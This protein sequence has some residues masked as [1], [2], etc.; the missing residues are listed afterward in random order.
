MSAPPEEAE[1]V[2]Q[3]VIEHAHGAVDDAAGVVEIPVA[4][5]LALLE[6]RSALVEAVRY[7]LTRAQVDP[8]LG[9]Y[10][11]PHTEAWEGLVTAEALALG[12]ERTE[13]RRERMRDLQPAHQVRRPRVLE[14]EERI[15]PGIKRLVDSWLDGATRAEQA[16]TKLPVGDS[17]R[18]GLET[19]ATVARACAADVRILLAADLEG[20][21]G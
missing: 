4:A 8:D 5:L 15:E 1:L 12:I 20:D 16:A 10:L 17:E 18:L 2:R 9:Y 21:D 19:G 3:L 7:V 11:S 6:Q 14:L 13:R